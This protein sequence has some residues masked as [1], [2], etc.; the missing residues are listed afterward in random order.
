MAIPRNRRE[1]QFGDGFFGDSFEAGLK[2][3]FG[4][5]ALVSRGRAFDLILD[6]MKIE[7]KTGAGELGNEGERALKGVS[8]ILYC[9]VF[10]PA[11]PISKQE[12]FVVKRQD[13]LDMLQEIGLYRASKTT[14]N[15]YRGKD[16]C[17]RQAIQTFWNH[18]QGKP[19]GKGYERL[20]DAL[21]DISEMSLQDLLEGHAQ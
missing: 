9:P 16:D 15:T 17:N 3:A 1:V 6:G 18:K 4:Q 10:N 13:F 11:L 5:P 12:A 20:I 2:A 8:R 14:T 21:Y 19:H 7:V